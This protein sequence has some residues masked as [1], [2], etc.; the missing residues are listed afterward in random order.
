M[1]KY[2]MDNMSFGV[3]LTLAIGIT[4]ILF[5]IYSFIMQFLLEHKMKKVIRKYHPKKLTKSEMNYLIKILGSLDKAYN[6]IFNYSK[7][8]SDV[9]MKWPTITAKN[10]YVEKE[11]AY[12]QTDYMNIRKEAL[13]KIRD[14]LNQ[15]SIINQLLS[16]YDQQ[17]ICA[18]TTIE[19]IEKNRYMDDFKKYF[20]QITSH[21]LNY[22]NQIT[23]QCQLIKNELNL[24]L[25]ECNNEISKL[26]KHKKPTWFSTVVKVAG[27]IITAPIRHS[28]NIII[29]ITDGDTGKILKS[30]AMLGVGLIGVGAIVDAL[31][32]LDG[33]DSIE[34]ALDS[35]DMEFVS[36]HP[37]ILP[38]GTEIWIDGDG[39][40]SIDL[41]I[42][43]GGGYY[44]S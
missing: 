5:I 23:N 32:I 19:K 3:Q 42:E 20:P 8:K 14:V 30:G 10:A 28:I 12:Y 41:S 40:S 18:A 43:E 36:P 17:K 9:F 29:G 24:K 38:D 25:I 15:K 21:R 16:Y 31:D 13:E 39:D 6:S 7:I 33:I 44:R 34:S 27:S 4:V 35:S 22:L 37:R 1:G 26:E 11:M 2:I